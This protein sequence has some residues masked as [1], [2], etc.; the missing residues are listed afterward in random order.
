MQEE[1]AAKSIL[2]FHNVALREQAA[3][4]LRQRAGASEN[5]EGLGKKR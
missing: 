4:F 5:H 1:S 3:I 2:F